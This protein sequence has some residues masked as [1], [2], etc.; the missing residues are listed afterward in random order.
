MEQRSE[1][2]EDD[3]LY[4]AGF[5]EEQGAQAK[6]CKWPLEAGTG[7]E[8]FFVNA[9]RKNAAMGT[10]FRPLECNLNLY[11]LSH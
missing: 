6:K 8:T 11:C 2:R 5:E 1:R 3:R 4:A 10:H 9:W 7:K